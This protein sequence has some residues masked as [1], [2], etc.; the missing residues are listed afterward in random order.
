MRIEEGRS[1]RRRS[2]R[3]RS[4]RRRS[5]RRRRR[6]SRRRRGRR[7]EQE[8]ASHSYEQAIDTYDAPFDAIASD[9]RGACSAHGACSTQYAVRMVHGACSARFISFDTT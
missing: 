5:S 9:L 2:S 3:R 8:L 1:S 4:S 6:R 7:R